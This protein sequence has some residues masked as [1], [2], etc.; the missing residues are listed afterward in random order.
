MLKRLYAALII[1]A[2]LSAARVYFKDVPVAVARTESA[3]V[4]TP[5]A[6]SPSRETASVDPTAPHSDK[7]NVLTKTVRSRAD[8]SPEALLERRRRGAVAPVNA[9][10]TPGA[11][12]ARYAKLKLK[13]GP[14][15]KAVRH[16]YLPLAARAVRTETYTSALGPVVIEENNLRVIADEN[17]GWADLK[18]SA[19]GQP[20]MVNPS[21][22][23]LV[24]VTGTLE[25]AL[26]DVE[27]AEALAEAEHLVLIDYDRTIGIA[28]LKAPVDYAL[29][30]AIGRIG[31]RPGVGAVELEI[32]ESR[33]AAR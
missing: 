9:D 6:P 15:A 1:L 10:V 5:A 4:T 2:V 18:T 26:P 28:F 13:L 22:G 3:P 25:V 20:L 7:P 21:N 27:R 30:P 19:D 14:P 8:V 33:K 16:G 11:P 31:A 29:L 23:R 24:L 17:D 32:V 12:L